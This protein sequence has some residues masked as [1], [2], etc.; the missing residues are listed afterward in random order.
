MYPLSLTI[1]IHQYP[2]SILCSLLN[3]PSGWKFLSPLAPWPPGPLASQRHWITSA[4]PRL[5]VKCSQLVALWGTSIEFAL[6]KVW[7][8]LLLLAFVIF[9]KTAQT[10]CKICK[11]CSSWACSNVSWAWWCVETLLCPP[12]L[13]VPSF[14]DFSI[15]SGCTNQQINKWVKGIQETILLVEKFS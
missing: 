13:A 15:I 11:H 8:C 6:C 9:V 12:K 14:P 3:Y 5:A 7:G 1:I 2:K 10:H 4:C